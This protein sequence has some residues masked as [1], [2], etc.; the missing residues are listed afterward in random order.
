MSILKS[1]HLQ[2]EYN[3]ET[4][5]SKKNIKRLSNEESN[6]VTREVIQISMIKLMG[7]MPFEKITVSDITKHAGVSR[8]AFYRNY[9]S[10]EALVEEICKSVFNE[11]D[12]SIKSERY[13]KKRK[14][15]YAD[16][17]RTIK[18]YN[19]YFRIY[20]DAHLQISDQVVLEALYPSSSVQERYMNTAREGAFISILTDWFRSGMQETPEEMAQICFDILSPL[21][22][23]KK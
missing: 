6:K 16:F 10:K 5:L 1:K 9:E 8:A 4:E 2:Q 21:E 13:H 22:G 15:W 20:L 7:K 3:M 14:V 11:L 12:A 18:E 17:F 23:M 19:E